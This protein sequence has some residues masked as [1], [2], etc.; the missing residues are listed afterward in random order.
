[1]ALC[2]SR[3]VPGYGADQRRR[4]RRDPH[5]RCSTSRSSGTRL[6][7]RVD[8]SRE[9]VLFCGA[10]RK[11]TGGYAA[12]IEIVGVSWWGRLSSSRRSSFAR[13]PTASSAGALTNPQVF[14]KIPSA[15]ASQFVRWF[16]GSGAGCATPAP[17][18]VASRASRVRARARASTIL[19]T[20][21]I[22]STAA[23]TAAGRAGATPSGC[24]SPACALGL[25]AGGMRLRSRL[26]EEED[27]AKRKRRAQFTTAPVYGS[28][29]FGGMLAQREVSQARAG[30]GVSR[31]SES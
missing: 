26:I 18:A 30:T 4:A 12:A 6:L 14:A 15:S 21:A 20:R 9:W 23:L 7:S 17:A 24:T 5:P 1:M 28:R 13:D 8:W 3:N 22:P 29:A 10:G 31:S 2:R 16:H 11:P 25:V 19:P 27:E